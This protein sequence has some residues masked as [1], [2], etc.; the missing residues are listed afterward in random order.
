MLTI[1]PS[2]PTSTFCNHKP[3]HLHNSTPLLFLVTAEQTE[4]LPFSAMEEQ[5]RY[6]TVG[7]QRQSLP[8][9]AQTILQQ[10]IT[11]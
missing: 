1:V 3:L 6:R 4:V 5:V 2:V 7:I 8:L 10:E 9:P 11:M